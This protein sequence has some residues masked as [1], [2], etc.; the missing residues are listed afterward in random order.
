MELFR[1]IKRD[2]ASLHDVAN[3]EIYPF[4]TYSQFSGV[5]TN[6]SVG[7]AFAAVSAFSRFCCSTFTAVSFSI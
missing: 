3:I 1:M 2:Y 6:V 4:C 5:G 7:R